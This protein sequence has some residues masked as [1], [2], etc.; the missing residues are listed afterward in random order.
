M[1]RVSFKVAKS[2]KEAG[3]P[4]IFNS[5]IYSWYDNSEAL[6]QPL[7]EVPLRE[8]HEK[9]GICIAPTYLEV[10]LWLW[11]E[12]DICIEVKDNCYHTVA[13]V[14]NKR[15]YGDNPEEAIITAI[16]YL[17]DNDLIK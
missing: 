9:K 12:K 11:C 8:Y 4:Q 16:E 6:F 10:W 17:V 15:F 7:S 3:Y 13:K 2:I 5:K 1:K 14:M